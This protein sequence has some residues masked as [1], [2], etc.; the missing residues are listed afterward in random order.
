ML[1][2][3]CLGDNPYLRMVGE[4]SVACT[5]M[6]MGLELALGMTRKTQGWSQEG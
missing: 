1:C 5:G 2:Q 4:L 3:T 6:K